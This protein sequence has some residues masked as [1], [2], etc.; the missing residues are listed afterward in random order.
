MIPEIGMTEKDVECSELN[1]DFRIVGYSAGSPSYTKMAIVEYENGSP[2]YMA[3][4]GKLFNGISYSVRYVDCHAF[5][6]KNRGS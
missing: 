1:C 4:D 2:P 5:S 6:E 3:S